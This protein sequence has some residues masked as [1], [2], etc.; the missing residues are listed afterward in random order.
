MLDDDSRVDLVSLE[1]HVEER[2]ADFVVVLSFK[3]D[4][5]SMMAAGLGVGEC[6]VAVVSF[7]E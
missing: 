5:P 2:R 6:I 1:E 4:G 7:P 3:E